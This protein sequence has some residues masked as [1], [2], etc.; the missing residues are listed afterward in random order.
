MEEEIT[1]S[2]SLIEGDSLV[3]T[4]E[5][6]E[7]KNLR[8][9]MS[10]LLENQKL[11]N[12]MSNR[13]EDNALKELLL[14]LVAKVFPKLL[15]NKIASMQP[16]LGPTGFL[17]FRTSNDI[18]KDS[19]FSRTRRIKTKIESKVDY[20]NDLNVDI[21]AEKLIDEFNEEH[22]DDICNNC[23]TVMQHDM[24]NVFGEKEKIESL[25]VK[26][27]EI[28]G[29][30]NQKTDVG[31]IT[32]FVVSQKTYDK[33]KDAFLAYNPTKTKIYIVNDWNESC[34]LMG[35][36][37]ESFMDSGYFYL[38]YVPFSATPIIENAEDS[39]PTINKGL[40][41]RYGKIL[42]DFGSN[43]YARLEII[44]DD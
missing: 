39:V 26:F 30:I 37:G 40:I 21:L 24:K 18:K 9:F 13:T 14:K 27:F 8:S 29:I 32:F 17:Y 7:D 12:N 34:V 28:S 38:P 19:I 22:L 35:Y 36:R 10:V 4:W 31:E 3:S 44:N 6:T 33:Y 25:C 43:Y 15:V 41:H 2:L 1:K 23:G 5:P 11:I 16:L 42:L 20:T